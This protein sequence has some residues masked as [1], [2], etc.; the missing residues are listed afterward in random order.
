MPTVQLRFRQ[1][2]FAIVFGVNVFLFL[3]SLLLAALFDS[4]YVAFFIGLPSLLVPLALYKLVGDHL[5]ARGSYGVSFMLFAALHIHQAQGLTEIHFGIFVLLAILFAFRD[6]WVII[7]A[8]TVI[9]VHHLLFMWLQQQDAGVY[10][11]PGA[12][13]TLSI[14]MLH[15]LYVVVETIVLVIMCR[16]ALR[17]AKVG[18][19]LFDATDSLLTNNGD[20]VLTERA[21]SLKSKVI[22]NF[23]QVL[24]SLQRTIKTL[25]HSATELT[26]QSESLVSQ[27]QGLSGAMLTKLQEVELIA[28]ATE[29]MSSN[30]ASL[31]QIAKQVAHY[32]EETEQAAVS[33]QQ[34][35][36]ATLTSVE[37]LSTQLTVTSDKVENMAV[38]TNDIRQVLDVIQAI[39]EQTNLLALNAAIEAARAGELGRGFAV[40][41]DEVRTLASRTQKSTGEIKQII[42]RLLS[43]SADSV[44]VVSHSVKQLGLTRDNAVSSKQL[45]TVIFDQAKLVSESAQTMRTSIEQQNTASHEVAKS[46]QMLKDMTEQQNRQGATVVDTAQSLEKLAVTL[47]NE[48]KKFQV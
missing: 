21:P 11:L 47:H 35:V 23:N 7:I 17:E 6:A 12:A 22:D 40:V 44:D 16:Y 9:A 13:N 43:Y 42:D 37:Q 38:A 24:D 4:W 48:T 8:A 10:L 36:A 20:I 5:L 39:A 15:A 31:H 25:N 45:L 41:A 14:V 3:V 28:A 33:G 30:L 27:G 32:A 46:T 29:Q 18:Q 2:A 26:R 34:S 19:A 1:Q